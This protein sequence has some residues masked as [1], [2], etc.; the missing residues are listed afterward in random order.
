[1]AGAADPRDRDPFAGTGLGLPDAFIG[2]DARTQD[3]R[4]RREIHPYGQAANV[5]R[6]P[7]SIFSEAAVNIIAGIVLALAQWLPSGASK[8]HFNAEVLAPIVV[9]GPDPLL[10]GLI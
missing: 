3:R 6:R 1:M 8:L 2:G 7:N 9:A 4:H 10:S 5:A